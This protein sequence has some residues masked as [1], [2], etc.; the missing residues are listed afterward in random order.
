MSTVISETN[1]KLAALRNI[2]DTPDQSHLGNPFFSNPTLKDFEPRVGFAWDLLKN[3]KTAV[4]GGI[5][6]FDVQPMPYQFPL[7]V[8]QAIPFFSYTVVKD[9]F[10]FCGCSNPFP[11]FGGQDPTFPANSKGILNYRVREEWNRIGR[12]HV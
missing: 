4:R 2:T 3:G 5:G 11:N 1:G 10:G 12:A 8:T 6:M 9:P 7:L